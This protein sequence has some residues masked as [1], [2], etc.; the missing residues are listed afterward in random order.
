MQSKKEVGNFGED[1]AVNF[2]KNNGYVILKQN[3]SCR[4]GEIDII[5]K[6]KK[7]IVFVEVKTRTNTNYGLPSEAVNKT[8]Q[9]HLI[10]SAKYYIFLNNLYDKFIRFDI[11]EIYISNNTYKINHIKQII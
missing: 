3:F 9:K 7:E 11:I 6:D 8:K 4:Q 2:L 5:C 1:L 10:N